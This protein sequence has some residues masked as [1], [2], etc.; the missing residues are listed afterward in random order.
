MKK[1]EIVCGNGFDEISGRAGKWQHS[2]MGFYEDKGKFI[3]PI[4][5]ALK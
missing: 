2:V 3:Q 4:M 5:V 1:V